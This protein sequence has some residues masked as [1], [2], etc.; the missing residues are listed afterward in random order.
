MLCWWWYYFL[1]FFPYYYFSL[2]F[3]LSLFIYLT[4]NP[5]WSVLY[6][7]WCLSILIYLLSFS[8]TYYLCVCVWYK[9]SSHFISSLHFVHFRLHWYIGYLYFVTLIIIICINNY[10]AAL[11]Q[12]HYRKLKHL[13][14]FISICYLLF[15][16]FVCLLLLYIGYNNANSMLYY[17]YIYI[18]YD[19]ILLSI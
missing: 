8:F 15:L 10:Y 16:Y 12:L 18:L 17:V 7:L 3:S 13:L 2:S 11:S 4:V 1:L 6:L 19:M 14:I 5:E 9:I